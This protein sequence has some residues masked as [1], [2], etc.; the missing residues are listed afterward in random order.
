MILNKS[1]RTKRVCTGVY[2]ESIIQSCTTTYASEQHHMA[3]Y[4]PRH[5]ACIVLLTLPNLSWRHQQLPVPLLLADLCQ[6]SLPCRYLMHEM[7]QRCCYCQCCSPW[8]QQMIIAHNS[9][10]PVSTPS[11]N[12]LATIHFWVIYGEYNYHMQ[13]LSV[14]NSKACD[15]SSNPNYWRPYNIPE[16]NLAS[17][18][19]TRLSPSR[20]VRSMYSHAALSCEKVH[21]QSPPVSPYCPW[22]NHHH[23]THLYSNLS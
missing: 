17:S 21:W 12:K 20:V 15:Y 6:M 18:L 16:C 9:Y 19:S 4:M 5:F 3:I 22:S 23:Q 1:K 13:N 11:A 8:H 10:T 2:V 14:T 7:T